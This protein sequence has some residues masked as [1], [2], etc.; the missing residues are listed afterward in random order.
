MSIHIIVSLSSTAIYSTM[1]YAIRRV[2]IRFAILGRFS[3]E[4]A[5]RSA[6]AHF[7]VLKNFERCYAFRRVSTRGGTGKI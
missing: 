6:S 2:S 5:C 3:L 1:D 4:S 7:A